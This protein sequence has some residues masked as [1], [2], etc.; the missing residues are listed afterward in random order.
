VFSAKTKSRGIKTV[1]LTL[2]ALCGALTLLTMC[3]THAEEKSD[4]VSS[5]VVYKTYAIAA[6]PLANSL[7]EISKISGQVIRFEA[8]DVQN[9]K[10]P[11]I[12]GQLAT[13]DALQLALSQ[14]GLTYSQLGNGQI[15]VH[16][17]Y[18]GALTVIAQTDEAERGYKVSRSSTAVR[19]DSELKD[20][21]QAI[22][23]IT[24]KAIEAQQS[25]TVQDV[26][27]NVAGVTLHESAQGVPTYKV[28]GHFAEG[29]LVNGV[30]NYYAGS[31]NIAGVE[32]VE[33]LKGPQAVLAGERSFGGVVNIV[34]KKP[35][36]E[37]IRDVSLSYGSHQ[38][39]SGSFDLAGAL[40]QDK[41]LSYRVIGS[42]TRQDHNDAGFD[43]RE[44]D[45]LLAQLRWKDDVTDLTGGISYDNQHFPQNR[46][47]FALTNQVQEEPEMVLGHP[48]DGFDVKSS[49]VFYDLERI[50]SPHVTLVSRM[51]YS[52]QRQDLNLHLIQSPS[53]V[54]TM[55]MNFNNS[56][57]RT[58]YKTTS[59]DHYLRF[60][61]DTG[62]VSH[63][64]STGMSHMYRDIDQ[65]YYQYTSFRVAVY[66]PTQYDFQKVTR[67]PNNW[68]SNRYS[69]RTD[70]GAFIQDLVSVGDWHFSAG[71]RRNYVS[72]GP[73]RNVSKTADTT[74]SKYESYNSSV[75]AGVIYNLTKHTSLYANYSEGYRAQFSTYPYCLG[76][77]YPDLETENKEIGIKGETRNGALSWSTAI[78]EID[79]KNQM[80][81]NRAQSCYNVIEAKEI[82]GVEVEAAGQILPGLNTVF[83]YNF[84]R[85]EDKSSLTA[86]VASNP[87]HQV[88]LF[89]NYD[90]QSAELKGFGINF[91]INS[92][93][94]FRVGSTE[95]S[96]Q[97]PGG[98]RIDFGVSYRKPDWSLQLGVKNLFDRTLYGFATSTLYVPVLEGRTATLTFK[99]S[100]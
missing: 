26:L 24:S 42:L 37:R 31:T 99:K 45:Y 25:Q 86:A 2:T 54:A 78:Y 88:N 1:N 8:V 33:V 10:A 72:D 34:T 98:T 39:I 64:L 48:S 57:N 65:V 97:A 14:S 62:P 28:R 56:S 50:L 74:S 27:E 30:Q 44:S 36:A 96:V 73:T 89:V 67:N 71:F 60:N 68:S 76:P 32:R 22:T 81:Y 5:T 53:S 87:K 91:G 82:R 29:G 94:R 13:L 12:E 41:K 21:P 69:S 40:T 47:T 55:T 16:V 11:A 75:N 7:R 58:E 83:G 84:S 18:L 90:F 79:E 3:T 95:S 46:Y 6:G 9:L 85:A 49:S 4:P 35:T 61:F 63:K 66:S 80:T 17:H 92:F 20:T 51:S 100:F 38:N 77:S 52:E 93:S 19:S 23:V 70:V 15:Q 43:G 59:G